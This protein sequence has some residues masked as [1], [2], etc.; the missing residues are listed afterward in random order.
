MERSILTLS[1]F[2]AC[3]TFHAS[4]QGPTWSDD[5]AC[6]VYSHCTGC[7][8]ANG[9]AGL[10]FTD[11]NTVYN[12]RDDVRDATTL[13]IMPPWPPDENYRTLAH[14]RILTQAEIDVIAA[15][16]NNGAPEG[17]IAN[18]PP[19]P[20]YTSNW[21][22]PSP[23]I[24]TRMPDYTVPVL[25][26]DMYRAFVLHINNPT[27]TYI[28]SFEVI[29]GNTAAVHHVLVFQD[30]T[31]Q[32]Q[33]LDD[34]D[35][36]PGYVSFGDVGVSSAELIGAWVPGSSFYTTPPFM[37][38]KLHA[39]ADIVI[40]VHYP[41][42]S[43]GLLDSTR[44]NFKLDPA[45][46]LRPLAINAILEHW[47]TMTDG[48][49]V[50]PPNQIKTFHDAFT[51]PALYPAT[52]TSIGP[53]AHL[54]CTSMK[55]Y[56]VTPSNDTILL[57]DIPKWDFHWQG[58]YDFRK[59]IH[60]LPGSVLHGEATYD[61]TTANLQNPNHANPQLVTLGE[62][63]T[64]EMMLFYF[65][66]TYGFPGDT[67]TVIDNSTHTAHYLNCTPAHVGISEV[68][69]SESVIIS[70]VPAH[71]RFTVTMDRD[72]CELMLMNAQGQ[73]VKQLRIVRGDNTIDAASLARGT[74][75]CVVRDQHG[76]VLHRSPIVLQ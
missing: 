16:V 48:P 29:P 43:D 74:Y 73:E 8:R 72:A 35:P 57:I 36:A 64:D 67:N 15:W 23:D 53:H 26:T 62:N 45:P 39:N 69:M 56:A 46:F 44:V 12:N 7:H 58:L 27:E 1:T 28:K 55:S 19:P 71:E 24:T 68:G 14:E 25:S 2:I 20:T 40:Q 47:Y 21:N 32:A 34:A 10:D 6:I 70:P 52:I 22:I 75:I 4:A 31:G 63:T 33:T 49:L 66:Y 37:G 51:I 17:N 11:Y 18:A 3:S 61:N 59:P 5:V 54:L 76:A 13:R 65:A 60:L 9:I 41:V 42:G 38:I 30:T 50:I